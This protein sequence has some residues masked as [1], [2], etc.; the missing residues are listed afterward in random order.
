M[1]S[2]HAYTTRVA[3]P[4]QSQHGEDRW[5][6]HY[7]KGRREGGFVEVGAYDG[8]VLSNTF[9]L[10]TV[11]WRGILVEPHPEKA[12]R[13]RENRPLARVFECAA[14]GPGGASV[15]T[16]DVVDGG[17]VYSTSAMSAEHAARLRSYGL[18]S[19]QI[20]VR[21]QTLD[22]ILEEAQLPRL[23]Y[24][25]IDVEGAELEV[26]R[27]FD[28]R[29]WRPSVVMIEVND[30]IRKRAIRD[31]FVSSGYVYL[32]RIGINEVYVPLTHF[33][34][35]ARA[36]DGVRYTAALLWRACA[37]VTRLFRRQQPG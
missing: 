25:S 31:V 14:V 6:E 2:V 37:R 12:A 16:F 36:V 10:E 23:D 34:S 13:C 17:E 11:G 22:S 30:R 33:K 18:R 21:A 3:G 27:G 35:L 28:L 19:R 8:I 29:R 5:L 20:E 15:V 1:N 32:R 24:A 9:F 4:Y 26:L 7:F